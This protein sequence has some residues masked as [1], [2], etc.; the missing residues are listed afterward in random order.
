MIVKR[1]RWREGRVLVGKT[2]KD[3]EIEV[4]RGKRKER[5]REGGKRD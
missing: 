5:A 1:E 3:V 4:K 2:K